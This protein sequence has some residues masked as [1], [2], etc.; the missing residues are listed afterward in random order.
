MEVGFE[1]KGMWQEQN[2]IK[3]KI[4]KICQIYM[5]FYCFSLMYEVYF[6]FLELKNALI[7]S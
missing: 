3:K 5:I 6:S 2:L 7:L 1:F 4:Y